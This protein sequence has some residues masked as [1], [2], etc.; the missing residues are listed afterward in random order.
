MVS[1]N[2]IYYYY[3]HYFIIAYLLCT[4]YCVQHCRQETAK[5]CET[6]KQKRADK[7]Y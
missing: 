7:L 4:K 3:Y 2:I 1:T 5:D 6:L